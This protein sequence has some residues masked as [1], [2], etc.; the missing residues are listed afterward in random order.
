MNDI[1]FLFCKAKILAGL[2]VSNTEPQPNVAMGQR[3]SIKF[4]FNPITKRLHRMQCL[5]HCHSYV[6]NTI[7]APANILLFEGYRTTTSQAG[8][9]NK[10]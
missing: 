6:D 5:Q 8:K 9:E 7:E 2:Q 1:Y 10:Q 4:F 3:G